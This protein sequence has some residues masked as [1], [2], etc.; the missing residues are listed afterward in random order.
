M[1]LDLMNQFVRALEK[2]GDCFKYIRS[3][4]PSLSEEKVKAG[5][6]DGPQ[7]RFLMKDSHF[8]GMMKPEEKGAWDSFVKVVA[9]F[10][11][12]AKADNFEEIVQNMLNC[13]QHLG[14]NMGI[15]MHFL[16]SH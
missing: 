15:K 5:I 16:H 2:D 10:W 1:K 6:F 13:F 7:I 8:I 11:G 12:N 14:C 4:F 9:N 3:K